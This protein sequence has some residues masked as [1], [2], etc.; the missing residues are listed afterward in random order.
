MTK[1]RIKLNPEKPKLIMFSRTL[2]EAANK[3]A[4]LTYSVQLSYFPHPK[5]LGITF[6]HNFSFK[7]HLRIF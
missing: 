1:W 3:P 7:K 6:D 2:K 5:F 4:L